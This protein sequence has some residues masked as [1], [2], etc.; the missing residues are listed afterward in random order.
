MWLIEN[1]WPVVMICVVVALG[2]VFLWS[3]NKQAKYLLLAGGMLLL[4]GAA[5][6]VDAAVITESERIALQV[7]ELCYAFQ[8]GEVDKASGY[9]S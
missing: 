2:G 3:R 1:P 7:Q 6:L 9:F 4:T 5:F 8:R